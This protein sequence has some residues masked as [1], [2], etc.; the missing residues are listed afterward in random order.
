MG[1]GEI[2]PIE[3]VKA[4]AVFSNGGYRIEPFFIERITDK[5]GKEI[6]S[7]NPATVCEE[8]ALTERDSARLVNGTDDK[9]TE[10]RSVLDEA[11]TNTEM[12]DKELRPKLAQRAV[13]ADNVWV[14]NSILRDVITAGTGRRALVLK[15]GDI[16]GKTG[17]T[18]DQKDAWFSGFNSEIVTTAW[19]GFDSSNT[20]GRRETGARAALPMWIEYMR[21]A[22]K[23]RPEFI[24]RETA[25]FNHGAD[26]SGNRDARKRE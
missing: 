16:A 21:E 7:A 25:G 13:S 15:R 10:P 1:S 22:L 5:F 11:S 18:N 17:T 8:C 12:E 20:L 19:V 9:G 24:R 4:Y 2:T 14:I 23:D 3:L 26:R 6:Y